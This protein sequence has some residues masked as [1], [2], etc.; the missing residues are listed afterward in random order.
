M[1][2]AKIKIEV[3]AC[4]ELPTIDG[5]IMRWNYGRIGNV[6]GKKI[7]QLLVQALIN[8]DFLIKFL[9]F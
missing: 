7:G 6:K 8:Q 5:K 2:G 1:T 4:E 9:K 3:K